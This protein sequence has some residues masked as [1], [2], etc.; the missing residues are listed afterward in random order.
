MME[1]RTFE[2]APELRADAAETRAIGY[3]AVFNQM[4]RIG[5]WFDE[6]IAPG[7][8]ANAINGGDIRALINHDTGRVIG[9]TT[10]GTLLLSEDAKGLRSEIILPDTTDG[11]DL[12]VSL[13]R[14]DITGMSFGFSIV[15]EEWDESGDMPK[16]TILEANLFEVSPVTFPAYEGTDIAMR[17]L[18]RS[19]KTH[20][21]EAVRRRLKMHL[22]LRERS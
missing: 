7:A 10:A 22:D 3:A 9:R 14:G 15:R 21:F 20:N 17:S 12:A 2:Q 1:K 5:S 11:R 6:V 4:T 13:G 19:R 18:E 8:F 16:R